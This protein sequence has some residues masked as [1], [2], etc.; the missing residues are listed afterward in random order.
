MRPHC[1]TRHPTIQG[2]YHTSLDPIISFES[3]STSDFHKSSPRTPSLSQSV[4]SSEHSLQRCQF[5]GMRE[6]CDD[7]FSGYLLALAAKAAE[8]QLREQALLAAFPNEGD[9]QIVE[10]FYN[11]EIENISE[12]NSPTQVDPMSR[13]DNHGLV[14]ELEIDQRVVLRRRSSDSSWAIQEMQM[15]QEKLS[16]L[17]DDQKRNKIP[18]DLAKPSYHDQFWSNAL[19]YNAPNGKDPVV[20]K[21]LRKIRSAANPPM[22]GAGLK[23]PMCPS[24]KST[25]FESDQKSDIKPNRSKNGGGLWGGYCVKD[26][27]ERTSQSHFKGLPL[28]QTPLPNESLAD[29]FVSE[30]E[31]KIM[32]KKEKI[33]SLP[34]VN[35]GVRRRSS[36]SEPIMDE[37]KESK[38]SSTLLEEFNDHFVT[39]VYNYLS[40]GFSS[41]A[42]Q[43]D[44][45]LSHISKIPVEALRLDD[46]SST[47]GHIGLKH[48]DSEDEKTSDEIKSTVPQKQN[49]YSKWNRWRALKIYILEWGKQHSNISQKS[50]GPGAWGVIARRGS[51]AV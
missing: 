20:E 3:G 42:W 10:H 40:L 22:L 47:Q 51:W 4:G 32:P 9:H 24:P 49:E 15:H 19:K 35:S 2:T 25:T 43:F 5:A 6:S 37:S 7:R 44:E 11:R 31:K 41:V 46:L 18:N 50:L 29:P 17:Q 33:P 23:F 21:E 45:E 36:V 26:E 48:T 1:N 38:I 14:T 28:I 27:T 13:L 16:Q 12:K 39:Q 30:F 34:G 8:K